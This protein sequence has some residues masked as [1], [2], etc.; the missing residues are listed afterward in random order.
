[1]HRRARVR[2]Y[3]IAAVLLVGCA[4]QAASTDEVEVG[5]E[6]DGGKAD[7]DG[8][9]SL[10]AGDTTV[11]VTQLI[12][13]RTTGVAT[14][15][16]LEGKTSRNLEG[17]NAFVIDDPFGDFA[18]SSPRTWEVAW[19]EDYV[20]MLADGTNQFVALNLKHSSGKADSVTARIQLRPRLTSISG[21]SKI[22]LTAELTPVVNN[23][24][25][26]YRLKGHTT[27][28]NTGVIVR[29]GA[30]TYATTA[31]SATEFTVDLQ[32]DQLF[33]KE[34][35]M[36]SASLAT[37][38]VDKRASLGVAIK[39]FGLTTDDPYEKWPRPT[40]T[41]ARKSCLVALGDSAF[42]TASCGAA[43]EV[44][45]C[46]STVGVHVDDIAF[47]AALTASHAKTG[48]AAARADYAALA[49]SD[50]VELLQG[51]AEEA[52]NG[53]LEA[54][55]NRWYLG[56]PARTTALTSATDAALADIYT[57]PL[58]YVEAHTPVPGSA[59][60][61]RQVAADA[62][63]LYLAQQDYLHS[64]FGRSYADLVVA[65]RAQHL[66]SLKAFRETIVPE[67]YPGSTTSDVLIGDWLGAHTEVTIDKAT[68]AAT[69]VLVELD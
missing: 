56:T 50:R 9:L 33:A 34:P 18:S 37:G 7:S 65:Y 36:L 22:Y 1:L 3:V 17:G 63:L 24:A 42:D 61:E 55:T 49:G 23:G 52:L 45:A 47:Q 44:L 11:W 26:F 58:D 6:D 19:S 53:A 14:Q 5:A 39:N 51:G 66:A 25:T 29:S 69:N 60:S 54:L 8:Q 10:R 41:S 20:R 4:E 15:Y 64:E 32:Q 31:V 16:V 38:T 2:T 40:C 43:L 68:G 12:E 35:L 21:S 46:S 30:R 59:D 48:S 67:A 28:P 62:L 27:S 13:R 57:R